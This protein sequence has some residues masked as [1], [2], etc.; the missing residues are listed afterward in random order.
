MHVYYGDI[1]EKISEEPQWWDECAVPR[2][3]EFS[4]DKVADIYAREVALVLIECQSCG[5]PFKVAFSY[6]VRAYW[7]EEKS[8]EDCVREGRIHYGDP[9][10]YCCAAGPTMNSVPIR[11]LEFW[12]RHCGVNTRIPEREIEL[13]P[14]WEKD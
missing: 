14:F 4:P 9:P 11:V 8:L 1:L 3:C 12:K 5:A 7:K 2:F 6:G 10:H 13:T